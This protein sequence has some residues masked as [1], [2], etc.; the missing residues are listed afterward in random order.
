MADVVA[1][2]RAPTPADGGRWALARITETADAQVSARRADEQIAW[3]REYASR[4]INS[5]LIDERR[6][7]P[8]HIAQDFGAAGL[9][10]PLI[11]ER[12]GGSGMHF[13][14]LFRVLEQLV[15]ID[16]ALGTWLGTSVFPGTRA[17]SVWAGDQVKQDWLPL[18]ATGRT[19]GAYAQTEAAAGSDFSQLTTV[20]TPD[21]AG[22]RL[23][24]SKQL[25]G[26]GTWAGIFTV[27]ARGQAAP[28]ARASLIALAV[29]TATPGVHPGEE[30]LTFGQRGMVQSRLHFTDAEV[31]ATQLLGEGDGRAVAMDSM[32]ASRLA[33][34]A[35][36]LGALKRIIQLAGRFADRRRTGGTTLRERAWVRLWL[37]ETI[38]RTDILHAMVYDLC[39][40]LDTG[41]AVE[42]EPIIGAKVLGSEWATEAADRLMQLMGGRGYD[43]ANIAA[44]MY[45][46]VRV[47]RTF[48][49]PSE[50][51]C[52]FLG[53]RA[54][55]QPA[56]VQEALTRCCGP[57]LAER[58]SAAL[59]ERR[60]H[61]GAGAD[62]SHAPVAE[63]M[64][65]TLA[66]G[67][68]RRH[69]PHH[70]HAQDVAEHRLQQALEQVRAV[71]RRPTT[72]S[73]DRLSDALH[74]YQQTIGDVAQH[75]PGSRTDVDVLLSA[76]SNDPGS[77]PSDARGQDCVPAL[78]A[79]PPGK[80]VAQ[81]CG[82]RDGSLP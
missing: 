49:G 4:R 43:E 28:G 76:T 65:W 23:N 81:A 27:L 5:W 6:C 52:D 59:G 11:E 18:L 35:C 58:F 29:P 1:T 75:L 56:K 25:I 73:D 22:W 80:P 8:P 21:G 2:G 32:S 40:R 71:C 42:I 70:T 48:E 60:P 3:L 54:L 61:G 79:L 69:A 51:L 74:R 50:A 26:N 20:A 37:A 78:A 64:L 17:L 14:D 13:A 24:G 72:V 10:G 66:A 45:R 36:A 44:R 19:L 68:V 30:H 7:I 16:T 82:T 9:F 62:T 33:I 67:A 46:D 39:G 63:A 15:A 34:A 12:Y 38:A 47:Y 53:R 31:S 41:Q 77:T 55:R 57:D